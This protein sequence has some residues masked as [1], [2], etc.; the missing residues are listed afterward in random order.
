MI[1]CLEYLWKATFSLHDADDPAAEGWVA[2]QALA[3]LAGHAARVADRIEEQADASALRGERRHGADAC[4]GY[5]RAK[6]E[7]LHYDQALAASWPIATGVFEGACR[8]LIADRLDITGARWSLIGAEAVLK[9]RAVESNGDC[10]A[11]FRYHLA[12]QHQHV[13]RDKYTLTA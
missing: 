4:A 12:R 7:Y 3:L 1:H 8:Y 11:Y 9:L 6:R 10:D 13:H 2:V 5:L